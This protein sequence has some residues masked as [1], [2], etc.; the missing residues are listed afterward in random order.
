MLIRNLRQEDDLCNGTRLII[1]GLY[2]WN[3]TARIIAGDYKAA[4]HTIPRVPLETTEGQLSFTLRR[5]QFPIRLCF[6]MTINK[7]QGQSLK[8]V[9]VL[10]WPAMWPIYR[11]YT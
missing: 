3:I 6:A 7:S 4:E 9:S 10:P 2:D 5:V 1:T 11:S 8:R